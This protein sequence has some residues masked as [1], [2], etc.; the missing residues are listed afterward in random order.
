MDWLPAN[1]RLPAEDS[2]KP[3]A[4]RLESVPYFWGIMHALDSR[5]CWM[6]ALQKAAQIGW[7][8]LLAADICRVA[9]TKPQRCLM[10]FPKD[11]KGRLFMD[12]K[13]V[14]MVEASPAV[15]KV[16]DV[17]TSRKSGSRTTRKRFPGGEV[18]A[19]G[20]NSVSNVK[21]TT[22]SRGYVEEPDDTNKDVGDQGD[23]IRHLRERLKRMTNKKLV[24]GG[25][26]SVAGLSQVEHYTRLGTQR[27]LPIR[28]HD[29]G[30]RHVLDWDNVSW[31]QKERGTPHQVFGMHLPDTAV[32]SCPHCGS[33]WS[34]YQR[35][36][37]ILNTCQ[38]ARD[39]GDPLAGWVKTAC[40]EGFGED[41]EEPIETFFDLSELYVCMDGT[42]L[43]DV[44]RDYLEAEHEFATGDD[45][46]R[47]VFQNNKLGRPYQYAADQVMD[48]EALAASAE[49]YPELT[50]PDGGLIVTAGVDVQHD[51]LAVTIRAFAR[52][53]ESWQLYWGE[54]D[55]NPIDKNDDCWAALDRLLFQAVPHERYGEIRLSAATIDASDGT[56]SAAVY[57]WVRTRSR[58]HRG[59]LLMAGKGDSNDMGTKEIFR[60]PQ[61]V[62]RVNP[63]RP[64]KADRH[65]VAVYMIGTHK[66]KDLISKRLLGTSARMHSCMHVRA[67]YWEQV[68][69]E[70]KAPSKRYRGKLTWQVRPGKRNEALDCEVY[71]LHAAYAVG[72][73][74]LPEPKWAALEARL[75]QRTLFN[76]EPEPET[77]EA[78]TPVRR[79]QLLRRRKKTNWATDLS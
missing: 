79:L 39:A 70:V 57:H 37:N 42:G 52:N 24:I 36:R 65:G 5:K 64:T 53:E 23:S 1:I 59:T 3:G 8:V 76:Q 62:D 20:S 60:L 56:T 17:S 2:A 66:A 61:T 22:A 9:A 75:G 49:D 50:C 27:V 6:V 73:H 4:Y 41:E 47:I 11:E 68:T 29:C 69:A 71:A 7:T 74:K 46:A 34:D 12:E 13:L 15:A 77:D 58:T 10:L 19:V 51:R 43:A 40:G 35:K 16:I 44:V 38:E 48:H 45:S 63:K 72:V 14:P 55:G 25:T 33:V 28:C 54:I 31:Q 78:D 30:E 32:Y 67:D 26:P 18:R 21:S